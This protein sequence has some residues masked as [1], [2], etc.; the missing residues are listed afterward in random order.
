MNKFILRVTCATYNH[1]LY[2]TE[3]LDG[4]CS[5]QTNF[6][7]VCVIVDDASNDGEQEIIKNYLRKNFDLNNQENSHIEET[8]D[9]ELIYA[10]HKKNSNCYFGAVLLKTNHY[11]KKKSKYQYYKPEWRNENVKYIA[12]CEGDDYWIDPFKLQKQFDFMESHQEY[13][14]CF[15]DAYFY[16]QQLG[17]IT[18]QF[19][20]FTEDT[21]VS[22][23]TM[24]IEGGGYCPTC[25]LFYRTEL[26]RDYPDFC[27]K[28]I[29]GD[30]PL[31]IYLASKGRVYYFSESMGV[32]RVG[33]IGSWSSH[34]IK[35]SRSPKNKKRII[36]RR[37]RLFLKKKNFY[38]Q[39][40]E[41]TSK[42]YTKEFDKRSD[43]DFYYFVLS[44]NIHKYINVIESPTAKKERLRYYLI[45]Y[46][47]AGVID[48][49]FGK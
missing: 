29:V 13:S 37:Y 4:F 14:L 6:P 22:P 3:T 40:N 16:N 43:I 45:K 26:M 10:R 32:Y 7:Y 36:L 12:L 8:Q 21:T 9:Y 34:Y 25:S 39:F 41:Y 24:I 17:K 20:R 5:Q 38:K 27:K 23:E 35:N 1:S 47:I 28:F 46:R 49:I 19:N 15:H 2:I 33:A 44:N 31:Q 11:C 48:W 30:Y 18:G 42:K